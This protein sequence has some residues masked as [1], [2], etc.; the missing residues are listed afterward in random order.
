MA[1]GSFFWVDDHDIQS[2]KYQT[3]DLWFPAS[4]NDN[5][6]AGG[7]ITSG[8]AGAKASFK[9]TGSAVAVYG[10][11]STVNNSNPPAVQ[12]SL[13]GKT[14]QT[15]VAPN[16]GSVD[17]SFP[18]FVMSSVRNG[19]HL[20]EVDVLNAT[21]QYPFALDLIIYEPSSGVTPTAAQS[22]ITTILPTATGQSV[23]DFSNS[24]SA[25]PVG[26]IVGG[27]L[28]GIVILVAASFAIWFICFRRRNRTGK[29]F[30]YAS[31][32]RPGDLLADQEEKPSSYTVVPPH[33]S[34]APGYSG[35][36]SAAVLPLLSTHNA[37]P[38]NHSAQSG[39]QPLQFGYTSSEAP[40]SEFGAGS[41][42]TSGPSHPPSLHLVTTAQRH[43][44]SPNQPGRS[45]AAEA[46]LLSV[47]H[48]ATFHADS[49]VHFDG[50]GRP[51]SVT[52]G[53]SPGNNLEANDI[54]DV[55]PS[56]TAS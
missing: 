20:L 42:L 52:D 17:L 29:A 31:A 4:V 39:Y 48:P 26:A 37:V 49:G 16:N 54:G 15:T 18:F 46:G 34:T 1:S 24:K 21:R 28:G 3:P 32:A 30:F 8:V 45:K 35:Y 14:V 6:A 27:A 9:F 41:S 38:S 56:Y 25:A 13:D 23:N 22:V 51:Q 10:I 33:Q 55:P 7:T 40:T 47:P 53:S 44:T 36:P 43:T 5:Q 2:I 50:Y 19:Q 11:V 12:F